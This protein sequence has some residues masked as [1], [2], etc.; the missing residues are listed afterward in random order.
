MID[1]MSVNDLLREASLI[2]EDWFSTDHIDASHA[3][4]LFLL[5]HLAYYDANSCLRI[6]LAA[7]QEEAIKRTASLLFTVFQLGRA[8]AM[9][10]RK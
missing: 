7:D 8:S 1:G 3:R 2:H 9:E 6:G 4:S 10:E 5:A